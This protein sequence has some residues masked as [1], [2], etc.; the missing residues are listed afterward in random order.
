LSSFLYLFFWNIIFLNFIV[1]HIWVKLHILLLMVNSLFNVILNIILLVVRRLNGS[2][3]FLIALKTV[4]I[5]VI[6][7]LDFVSAN[8]YWICH[9]SEIKLL[10]F[11]LVNNLLFWFT[12]C[13]FLL[14][15]NNLSIN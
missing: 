7:T 3:I 11:V 10:F 8:I 12:F 1:I 15:R 5:I 13:K 14:W 9:V 2:I 6:C 4:V